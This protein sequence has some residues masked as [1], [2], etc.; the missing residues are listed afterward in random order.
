MGYEMPGGVDSAD[1]VGAPSLFACRRFVNLSFGGEIVW[2]MFARAS[3]VC[4]YSNLFSTFKD[5]LLLDVVVVCFT[6]L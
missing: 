1:E 5:L 4:I 6:Q 3:V 2:L